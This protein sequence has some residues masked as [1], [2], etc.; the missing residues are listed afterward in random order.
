MESTPASLHPNIHLQGMYRMGIRILESWPHRKPSNR[1]KE[2][3]SEL[4]KPLSAHCETCEKDMPCSGSFQQPSAASEA[5][6][7]PCAG[8]PRHKGG[9]LCYSSFQA[10]SIPSGVSLTFEDPIK[11]PNRKND[12]L[13]FQSPLGNLDLRR[14]FDPY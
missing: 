5:N 14:Y 1:Q 2:G 6:A 7:T 4:R 8:Q 3:D 12:R 13:G 10:S 9:S 11:L